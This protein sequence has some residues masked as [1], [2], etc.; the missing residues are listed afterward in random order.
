M[1]RGCWRPPLFGPSRTMKPLLQSSSKQPF[2]PGRGTDGANNPLSMN[3]TFSKPQQ[4]RYIPR[5]QRALLYYYNNSKQQTSSRA[6]SITPGY[7]GIQGYTLSS[8]SWTSSTLTGLTANVSVNSQGILCDFVRYCIGT[9]FS[10]RRCYAR[11][12]PCIS[13]PRKKCE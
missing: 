4:F 1:G 7:T 9:P 2:Q 10:S 6:G 5:L 8:S 11:R 12:H 13:T 3:P